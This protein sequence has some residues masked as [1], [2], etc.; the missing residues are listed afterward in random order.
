MFLFVFMLNVVVLSKKFIFMCLLGIIFLSACIKEPAIEDRLLCLE[1]TSYSKAE[2]PLC[3]TQESCFSEVEK[4]YS[5]S[6]SDFPPL[7]ENNLSELKNQV[8]L[9]WLYFNRSLEN[10]KT[11]NKNCLNS[12]NLIGLDKT[13]NEL[14]HNLVKAFEY[15]DKAHMLAFSILFLQKSYL[16]NQQVELI[17]EEKIFDDFIGINNNL[18]EFNEG[19]AFGETSFASNYFINVKR[20]ENFSEKINFEKTVIAQFTVFDL[21]NGF[22]EEILSQVP[23]KPFYFPM[24]SNSVSS[25]IEYL[26]N[27]FT[28]Q[29]A[30]QLLK[31][32][33][34]FELFE[35]YNRFEGK[36]NSSIKEFFKLNISI[37]NN[38]KEINEKNE[39][40]KENIVQ[41]LSEV[42]QKISQID[43]QAYSN[44]DKEFLLNL[45]LILSEDFS[46]EKSSFDI[47]E[48][49]KA[50]V[51]A[52]TKV[53]GLRGEFNDL[54]SKEFHSEITIGEKTSKLK[55]LRSKIDLLSENLDF[56]TED[57]FEA[58][59]TS[60][61]KRVLFIG[62]KIAST[63]FSAFGESIIVIVEE[64][65]GDVIEYKKLDNGKEK[66]LACKSIIEQFNSLNHAIE[67]F[68]E[69][70]ILEELKF[71]QCFLEISEIFESDSSDFLDLE[72]IY[73]KLKARS[74]SNSSLNKLCQSLKEKVDFSFNDLKLVQEITQNHLNSRKLF[75]QLT[76]LNNSFPQMI[77]ANSY[78]NLSKK[79]EN[80][81]EFFIAGKLIPSK[82]IK[83][84]SQL[85]ESSQKLV[86]DLKET[87]SKNF[88][89]YLENNIEVSTSYNKFVKANELT[90]T[91]IKII[92][93]NE[94]ADFEGPITLKFK[95]NG[96]L[97][98][99]LESLDSHITKVS[100]EKENL[101]VELE[102]APLGITKIILSSEI[103][104]AKTSSEVKPVFLT[105]K[106]ALIEKEI[107]IEA[108]TT[109]S[110][111]E[112]NTP[113][114]EFSK[115]LPGTINVLYKQQSIP[116]SINGQE[117]VFKLFNVSNNNKINIFYEI[118]SPLEI[119]F[120]L[121]EQNKLDKTK[122]EYVF[123]AKLKNN[124]DFEFKKA[125]IS[126]PIP[127]SEKNFSKI[128][129]FDQAGKAVS[130]DKTILNNI[131][132]IIP[133]IFP[134]QQKGFLIKLE[135]ENF[136]NYWRDFVKDLEEK[137]EFLELS[138]SE[139]LKEKKQNFQ[140]KN[141]F[142]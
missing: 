88:K 115:I 118:K 25:L 69:F 99:S 13:A 23:K 33:P 56:L 16:E 102:N 97:E 63:D 5:A 67:N 94:L 114:K 108:N 65:N 17:K 37:K 105:E 106:S 68:E 64:T 51:D 2:I 38:I 54:L 128:K 139:N 80:Q 113:L 75:E 76:V 46:I 136:S 107:K 28:L 124:T 45:A 85:K 79:L 104:F 72:P 109:I 35:I 6:S 83:I 44:F 12:T 71:G 126:L 101:I 48:F 89:K 127:A 14:N 137:I 100:L 1:L 123:L 73:L 20:F 11:I 92:I 62:E 34:S 3:K 77:S 112:I 70:K 66:L 91:Q 110:A 19:R 32:N 18:N 133:E 36:Q 142:N 125:R 21:I 4:A 141:C 132:I 49:D 61:E 111:L 78:S 117:I 59:S 57:T 31:S 95:I 29:Q 40:E 10:L 138:E 98:F 84:L 131:S 42:D 135:V 41:R 9:S 121:M 50:K 47:T 93:K 96:L 129:I 58:L 120:E 103:E 90:K 7:I 43:N 15:N 87:Y 116:F 122:I 130:F 140:K 134:K 119:D 39:Q 30:V 82:S 60:C 52:Q 26:S 55:D 22:D 24:I 81:K 53:L 74:H 86:L 8:A 27:T